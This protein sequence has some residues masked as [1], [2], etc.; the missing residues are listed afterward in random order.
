MQV[1]N[2]LPTLSSYVK[3]KLVAGDVLFFGKFLC[4]PDQHPWNIFR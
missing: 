3:R 2:H 1:V 4:L